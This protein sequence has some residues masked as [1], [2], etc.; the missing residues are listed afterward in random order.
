ME[1]TIVFIDNGYLKLILKEFNNLKI[2]INKLSFNL[3]KKIDLWCDSVYVYDAPPYQ[4]PNSKE[5]RIRKK[6]YDKFISKLRE[7]KIIVREGRCQKIG[8]EF[9]QKG[10][11]TLLTMDL[12]SIPQEKN[13]KNVILIACD[14]DF[15]PVLEKI[16]SK[17]YKIYLFHYNDYK[18]KSKFSMSNHLEIACDRTILIKK[19][20]LEKS[21]L[22]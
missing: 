16:R 21:K 8:N 12:L 14:T 10:V 9:H 13:I 3:C 7:K 1:N 17:G 4:D 19:D 22:G 20:D 6:N 18:R 2:D 5:D 11:D 15:V